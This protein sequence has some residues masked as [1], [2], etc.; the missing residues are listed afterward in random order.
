MIQIKHMEMK[1]HDF[2]EDGQGTQKHEGSIFNDALSSSDYIASN[3][4][5]INE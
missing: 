2:P 1:I 3:G 5:M 4:R